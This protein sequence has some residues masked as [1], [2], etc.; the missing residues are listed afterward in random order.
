MK[1]PNDNSIVA[2]SSAIVTV[3]PS[4]IRERKTLHDYLFI[5]MEYCESTLVEHVRGL[6]A[7]A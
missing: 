4:A 6:R 1:D 2:A 5:L 7:A 3:D